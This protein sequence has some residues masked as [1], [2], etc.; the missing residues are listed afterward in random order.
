MARLFVAIW[1]PDDVVA[2]LMSLRRKDQRG[3]RFV[4]PESWHVTLRFLGEADIDEASDALGAVTLPAATAT[5]AP[6][7][8][9]L[10]GRALAIDVNGL[11]ELASAVTDATSSV[12]EPPPK[13]RY[14]AHLTIARLKGAPRLP[15]AMGASVGGAFEVDSVALVRSRLEPEGARYD[16]VGEWPTTR[17]E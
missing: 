11:D 16:T 13:R 1:P 3:V 2:D 15:R 17:Q 9:V 5:L 14:R 7:V 10:S 8:D 6:G 12:G 4:P